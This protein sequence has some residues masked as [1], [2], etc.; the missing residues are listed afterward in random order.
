MPYINREDRGLIDDGVNGLRAGIDV[1]RKVNP[2][3]LNYA[4]TKL[5]MDTYRVKDGE[6]KY[7]DYNEIIG[8]LE[9]CKLE[10]Y[11]AQVAPYEDQKRKEN[12]DV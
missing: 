10:F 11:R 9:C 8:V 3:H 6:L 5:I 7:A 12:G 4:I 1:A 2:G